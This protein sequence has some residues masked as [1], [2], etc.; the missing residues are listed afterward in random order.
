[1][2]AHPASWAAF[3]L[4]GRT[5]SAFIVERSV[6]MTLHCRSHSRDSAHSS[7]TAT[8]NR[9]IYCLSTAGSQ[10]I[11]GATPARPCAHARA[12]PERHHANPES[13]KPDRVIAGAPGLNVHAWT[14]SAVGPHRHRSADPSARRTGGRPEIVPTF[15]RT[16]P[17]GRQKRRSTLR[18]RRLAHYDSCRTWRRWS[19]MAASI[20]LSSGPV[21][22]RTS[23]PRSVAARIRL[24]S[25]LLEAAIPSQSYRGEGV[26]I[27]SG[28]RTRHPPQA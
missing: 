4:H 14:S 3:H 2:L 8:A 10:M 25:G 15:Q 21:I 20:R 9:R 28:D 22:A 1:M 18:I 12:E 19:G 7:P 17:P 27:R 24:D 13:N 11:A 23:L 5:R 6:V 26:R 16:P